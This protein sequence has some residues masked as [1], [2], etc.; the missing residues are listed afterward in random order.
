MEKLKLMQL[1]TAARARAVTPREVRTR[2]GL[3]LPG[4]DTKHRAKPKINGLTDN[5]AALL[6]I[7]MEAADLSKHYAILQHQASEGASEYFPETWKI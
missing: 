6:A 4:Q 2:R 7:C 1:A 3:R 5:E